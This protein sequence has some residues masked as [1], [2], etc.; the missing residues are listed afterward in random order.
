MEGE[1]KQLEGLVCSKEALAL[2]FSKICDKYQQLVV[3]LKDSYAVLFSAYYNFCKYNELRKN[4]DIDY[5][6]GMLQVDS[7]S[8]MEKETIKNVKGNDM[9]STYGELESDLNLITSCKDGISNCC[10]YQP[11]QKVIEH[12]KN[13]ELA[14]N[15]YVDAYLMVKTMI[16]TVHKKR[17]LKELNNYYKSELKRHELVILASEIRLNNLQF[18]CKKRE[19]NTSSLHPKEN[20]GVK[21]A[22][23]CRELK[24]IMHCCNKIILEITE[25]LIPFFSSFSIFETNPP[26][27]DNFKFKSLKELL[28]ESL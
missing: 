4:G 18:G 22:E 5:M 9:Y 27:Y 1:K 11:F 19:N 16:M 7:S 25:R 26:S 10:F 14:N 17:I 28:M 8:E 6:S 21:T 12:K 15:N 13:G 23:E 2:E 3:K 24:N 20:T